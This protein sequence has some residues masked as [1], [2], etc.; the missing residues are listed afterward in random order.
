MALI[1]VSKGAAPSFT[2]VSYIDAIDNNQTATLNGLNNG[3]IVIVTRY[4]ADN[5]V[6]TFTLVGLSE[7]GYDIH[8]TAYDSGKYDGVGAF[9]VTDSSS[10]TLTST[11]G[12][13]IF[14]MV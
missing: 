2:S 5:T 4:R 1:R 13:T 8:E 6:P 11:Q 3:D 14:K 10:C 9:V 7:I 12:V